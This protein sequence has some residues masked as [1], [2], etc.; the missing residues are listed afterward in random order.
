MKTKKRLSL[1][2]ILINSSSLCMDLHNQEF[3]AK[4]T[5]TFVDYSKIKSSAANENKIEKPLQNNQNPEKSNFKPLATHIRT[6]QNQ[7]NCIICNYELSSPEN[8]ELHM[9]DYHDILNRVQGET[10]EV[11]VFLGLMAIEK[12]I[13]ENHNIVTNVITS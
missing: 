7:F 9:I 2:F 6:H 11:H 4:R 8:L 12:A 3:I 5:Y 10:T 1:I 13:R